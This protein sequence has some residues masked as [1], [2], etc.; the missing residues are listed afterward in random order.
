MI[1]FLGDSFTWGQGL[2]YY[3][4]VE[5]EGW[6]WDDCRNF[7]ESKKRFESLG[8]KAD[9][10][11]RKNSFPYLVSKEL[12]EPMITPHF[13]NGG[14]NYKIFRH[15]DNVNMYVT[16][17]NI[18][19]VIVQ[20][21]AP[22]RGIP[23]DDKTDNIHDLIKNQIIT[24]SEKCKNLGLDWYA[25]SWYKEMGDILKNEY[26]KHYIPILYNDVEYECFEFMHH[27]KLRD[28]TIQFTKHIDDGH[29]NLEGHQ[30]IANSIINK[31]K[32]NILGF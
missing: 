19:R 17:N 22:T 11:R 1:L 26:T 18:S 28:L 7:L 30:V 23:K 24:V 2:H 5:N 12:N 25:F 27:I 15:L 16:V 3:H 14:D 8:F 4:L 20:F 13:E 9:E 21:S 10:F 6:S 31:L 32:S 29:F